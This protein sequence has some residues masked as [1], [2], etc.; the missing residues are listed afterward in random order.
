MNTP[1][2]AN[3][4]AEAEG[5][6]FLTLAK[7]DRGSVEMVIESLIALLDAMAPDPDLEPSL[8]WQ[9]QG[10]QA[11]LGGSADDREEENEHGGDIQDEPHDDGIFCGA[12]SEPSSGW[13]EDIDQSRMGGCAS[14]TQHDEMEPDLGFVGHGTG[15]RKSDDAGGHETEKALHFDGRGN[16]DGK[17]L[18]SKAGSRI[19]PYGRTIGER[20]QRMPDGT[21]MRTFVPYWSDYAVVP[22]TTRG[23]DTSRRLKA[24]DY[25]RLPW[26]DREDPL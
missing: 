23:E 16:L 25:D 3:K 19:E 14:G 26:A 18:V 11:T 4:V 13:T 21:I 1:I 20:A 15:W 17:A 6:F 12:D 24:S 9:E 10:S 22:V 8:G 7:G 2:D 5:V